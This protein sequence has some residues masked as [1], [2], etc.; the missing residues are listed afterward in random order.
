MFTVTLAARVGDEWIS[1][2]DTRTVAVDGWGSDAA[3]RAFELARLAN[4]DY[5]DETVDETV[6]NLDD[7]EWGP[8][9]EYAI[10]SI[11]FLGEVEL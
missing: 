2:Y 7:T 1:H 10:L 8:P 6:G 9:S 4:G 3:A 11:E 5:E